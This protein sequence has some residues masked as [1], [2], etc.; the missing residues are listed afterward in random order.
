VFL[1][2]TAEYES[3]RLDG[4]A[5]AAEYHYGKGAHDKVYDLW[6]RFARHESLV[7][8]RQLKGSLDYFN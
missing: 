7:D 3:T 4:I 1:E 6:R 5:A 8:A 2:K